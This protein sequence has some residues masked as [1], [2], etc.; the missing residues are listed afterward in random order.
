ML[1]LSINCTL[2]H[3]AVLGALEHGGQWP[4]A[5]QHP[6]YFPEEDLGDTALRTDSLVVGSFKGL[7]LLG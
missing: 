5:G 1:D 2:G 7:G 3:N 6:S 4:R